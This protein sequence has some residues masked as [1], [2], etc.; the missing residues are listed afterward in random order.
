MCSTAGGTGE[1]WFKL[2]GEQ[3]LDVPASQS[4]DAVPLTHSLAKIRLF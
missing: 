2:Y 1:T 3:K 4:G